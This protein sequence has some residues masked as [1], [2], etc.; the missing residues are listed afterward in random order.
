MQEVKAR[1]GR[2]I[3]VTTQGNTELLDKGLA[4][5][6]FSFPRQSSL[7]PSPLYHSSCLSAAARGEA[8]DREES[9]QKRDRRIIADLLRSIKESCSVI[10]C[11]FLPIFLVNF[12]RLCR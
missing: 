3:A 11:F 6:A 7:F 12:T 4:D 1:K 10:S 5:G 8:I 2:I 9:C